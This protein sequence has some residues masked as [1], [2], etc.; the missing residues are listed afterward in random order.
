MGRRWS[1]RLGRNPFSAR[2]GQRGGRGGGG[3]GAE[4]GGGAGISFF[5][6]IS[7]AAG[8][9]LHRHVWL[10]FAAEVSSER[11]GDFFFL[12]R[13]SAAGDCGE[14]RSG[15][16]DFDGDRSASSEDAAGFS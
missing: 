4:C 2:R 13:S 6:R 16:R 3:V 5:V 9:S 14:A 12:S 11:A 7:G 1:D 8:G 10:G 15:E